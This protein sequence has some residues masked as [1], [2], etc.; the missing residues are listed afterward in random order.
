MEYDF[1]PHRGHLAIN[2]DISDSFEGEE[3]GYGVC[4]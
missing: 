4:G 3:R 1:C 2:R